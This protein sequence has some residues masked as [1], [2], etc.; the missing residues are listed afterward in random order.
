MKAKKCTSLASEVT[1][2]MSSFICFHLS[3]IFH[4]ILFPRS[5]VP[6]MELAGLQGQSLITR[7]IQQSE[8]RGRKWVR[9]GYFPWFSLFLVHIRWLHS[10]QPTHTLQVADCLYIFSLRN[11]ETVSVCRR[12]VVLSFADTRTWVLHCSLV[13]SVY[14]NIILWY[15]RVLAVMILHAKI[16]DCKYTIFL[17]TSPKFTHVPTSVSTKKNVLFW[18]WEISK[19]VMWM[20][21]PLRHCMIVL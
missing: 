21:N 16:L 17:K 19:L 20:L 10:L 2:R 15:L 8:E 11:L 13:K 7:G 12:Q 6:C 4:P 14:Q 3:L 1:C 9:I 5:E 18:V